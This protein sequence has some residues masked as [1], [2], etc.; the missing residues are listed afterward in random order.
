MPRVS[1]RYDGLG[2]G[3][4]PYLQPPGPE[5]VRWT[6]GEPGFDTP[7]EIIDAAIG[8]LEDGNTKYTRGP[9][10][11]ELCEAVA[12]Y[13]E[14]HHRIIASA[15]DIVVTPGAKQAL[16]YSFMI[17]TMPG[18]EAILLA[19]S[20]AS[21]EPM[22]EFIGAV[23]VHVPVNMEN[24]HPDLDGI[25]NA[26]TERTRMILINSPCNP[27][28][29][30]F[31]PEE[32][33]E[34]V[35]IA[36]DNDLWIVSDEIYARMVWVDWPHVSPATLPGGRERTIVINGWSKSWAMTGMRVG[37]LTGPT[38]AVRA[39]KKSQANS[40]SHIPTFLMEAARVALS[41]EESVEK[42]NR[43]YLK[44]REIMQKGLS[45]IP[46]IRVPEPEGAFYVFADISGTGMSDIEFADGALEAGV[47]LIPASLITGG[48]GFVRISYAADEDAILEGLSRIRAWLLDE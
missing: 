7:K 6:V 29:A 47:Q 24:F 17:T 2:V 28:G 35:Q 4:A 32:M 41:C 22:L 48:D 13:L 31:T 10:S 16:L 23:P 15:E 12:E 38:E 20:W 14:Q 37:F 3:F 42:F 46:G 43:E 36:V 18:D 19:P 44:R 8:G 25:R 45:S 26:I 33:S 5:V 30:V 1:S 39:A 27:T 21:Y 9:G 11:I 40:A 34:I